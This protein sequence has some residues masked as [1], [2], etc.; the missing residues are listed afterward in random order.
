MRQHQRACPKLMLLWWILDLVECVPCC[1]VFFPCI[2]SNCNARKQKI[3]VKKLLNL[4]QKDAGN[5]DPSDYVAPV[6]TTE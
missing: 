3:P 2:T 1:C 5:A 6:E 4:D